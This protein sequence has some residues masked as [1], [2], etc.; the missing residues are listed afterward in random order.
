M[1]DVLTPFRRLVRPLVRLSYRT[2]RIVWIQSRDELPFMLNG[3]GLVGE[4]AE[5]GVK[6]GHFSRYL[7][8]HWRGSLLHSIDPWTA[9]TAEIDAA[10][11]PISQS[12]HDACQ[13]EA[14]ETLRRFGPRSNVVRA[15]SLEAALRFRDGSL[16]F[17]Y[18]DALH[19]EW[20][21]RQDIEAWAP[22]VRRGGLLSGHDYLDG[23]WQASVFGVKTVVDEYARRHGLRVRASREKGTPS[24]LLFLPR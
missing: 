3:L 12:E 15:P 19:F 18:I 11:R 10:G 23:P 22:K 2:G 9:S 4:G 20:A 16:D 21:I 6:Q 8:E 13:R 7:L 1:A 5:I 17:C 24:W 14:V